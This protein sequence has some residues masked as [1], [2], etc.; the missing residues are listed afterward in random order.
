M[1]PLP[2]AP[3]N[4]FSGI[5]IRP[6]RYPLGENHAEEEASEY[7]ELPKKIQELADSEAER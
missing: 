7:N 6:L 5:K 3:A 4:F 1:A 2:I